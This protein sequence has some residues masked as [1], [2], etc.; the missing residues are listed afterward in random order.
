MFSHEI[1]ADLIKFLSVKPA[2]LGKVKISP[3]TQICTIFFILKPLKTLWTLCV[4][5]FLHNAL[6]AVGFIVNDRER[7]GCRPSRHS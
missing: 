5:D 1:H 6:C 7:C 3:I 4:R 2:D